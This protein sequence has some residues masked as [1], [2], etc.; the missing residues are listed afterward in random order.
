MR[1]IY[2][3]YRQIILIGFLTFLL[4]P[5]IQKKF[6]FIDLEPLSGAITPPQKAVFSVKSWFNGEYQKQSEKYIDESFGFRSLFIRSHNQIAF[7]IFNKA[8]ANGVLIGKNN[9]LYEENYLKAYNGWDF[10]GEKAIKSRLLKIKYLQDTLQKLNKTFILI[11]AAGK[12]SFYPEYFPKAYKVKP[13]QTNYKTYTSLCKKMKINHI[14]FN[15]YFLKQKDKSNYPLYPKY[16]IHWS[17]YGMGIAADSII[18]YIEYKRG[19]KMPHIYW[20][21]ITYEDAKESDYDIGYGMNLLHK[22]TDN[23]MAYPIYQFEQDSTK[24]KPRSLFISDSFFWGMFNFGI[25]NV[26]TDNQF[27]YYN[28]DVYP[29]SYQ[30][31]LKAKDIQLAKYIKNK[32]VIVIMAT[33]AVLP[34]LGWGAIERMYFSYR[35]IK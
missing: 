7:S 31:P 12:G 23:Q 27:W 15:A 3:T 28:E 19:I 5:A 22:F 14:D 8:K 32:D 11:F 33:E 13:K 4:L 24:I 18:R 1:K 30:K 16:G 9:Y 34:K 2:K 10:V 26:F 20:N 21:K 17:T 35:K 25:S 6:K 29:E